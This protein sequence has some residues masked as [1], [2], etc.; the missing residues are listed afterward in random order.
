MNV[1]PGTTGDAG[2]AV[3]L[4]TADIQATALRP[5]PTP[6]RGQ[7][8]VVRVDDAEQGREMLRRLLPH[9][10]PADE[11]WEPELE[12]WLGVAF[13]HHGL[14]ALGLPQSSLD[15]FPL[16]FREGMAARAEILND[17]DRNSPEHWEN[18]FG[19]P[20]AHVFIA[21]YARDEVALDAMLRRAHGSRE[22]LS[23][24]E[25]VYRLPFSELPDGRNPFGFRDGLHNPVIEGYGPPREGTARRP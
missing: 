3:L 9:V 10:A 17:L 24:V 15:S 19:T 4:D 6:Y 1:G 20:D 7:Y 11:T 21:I 8:V 25:V 14:K 18:P 23:G 13:T 5:R 12:G 2:T 22:D 16:A